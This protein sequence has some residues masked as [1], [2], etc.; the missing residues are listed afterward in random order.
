MNT[1]FINDTTDAS[2][3][4]ISA[5][6]INPNDYYLKCNFTSGSNKIA[7]QTL[8]AIRMYSNLS[9]SVTSSSPLEAP[10][11]SAFDLTITGPNFPNCSNVKCITKSGLTFEATMDNASIVRCH[12]P[13]LPPGFLKVILAFST[14]K[15]FDEGNHVTVSLFLIAANVTSAKFQNS[16]NKISITLDADSYTSNSS[17]SAFLKNISTLGNSPK[18]LLT[19]TRQLTVYLGRGASIVPGDTLV[20]VLSSINRNAITKYLAQEQSVV[21]LSPIKPIL[22]KVLLHTAAT[23]GK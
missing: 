23:V 6:S 1:Q 10:A 20:F 2:T 19:S 21:V 5:S 22:P 8:N 16:L 4:K 14:R 3:F 9:T 15:V 12:V 13:K 18:C 11:N 7:I 17:C